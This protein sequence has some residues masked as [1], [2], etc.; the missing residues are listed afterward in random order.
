MIK[1]FIQVFLVENLTFVLQELLEDLIKMNS[2]AW[3][4][5]NIL[6][7]LAVFIVESVIETFA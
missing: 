6:I 2:G 1:K 5:G 3:N 4:A 7:S